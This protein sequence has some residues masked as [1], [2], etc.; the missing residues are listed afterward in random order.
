MWVQQLKDGLE[1]EDAVEKVSLLIEENNVKIKLED[2]EIGFIS[3]DANESEIQG[4]QGILSQ[5]VEHFSRN[6]IAKLTV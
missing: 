2:P 3:V 4:L 5:S 1:E 6:F